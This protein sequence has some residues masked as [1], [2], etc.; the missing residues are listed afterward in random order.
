MDHRPIA[1]SPARI[2]V[3]TANRQAG[4][5]GATAMPGIERQRKVANRK[6]SSRQKTATLSVQ[7]IL[8]DAGSVSQ[9]N[10]RNMALR[11][12]VW[13]CS[14]G[15]ARYGFGAVGLRSEERRVG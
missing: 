15:M 3:R 2:A 12:L 13:I 14:A 11:S 1:T 10:N 4:V 5:T 9:G 8:G 6:A 7:E